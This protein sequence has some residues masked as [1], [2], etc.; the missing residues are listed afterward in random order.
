MRWLL[1][2]LGKEPHV[3]F[4][5]NRMDEVADLEDETDFE[6]HVRVKRQALLQTLQ[7]ICGRP[8]D[9]E[10]VAISADPYEQGLEDWLE[11]IEEY[12]RLSRLQSL[13]VAIE[14]HLGRAAEQIQANAGM[15]SVRDGIETV[16]NRLE[17][18]RKH[19]QPVHEMLAQREKE[20]AQECDRLEQL[21]NEAYLGIREDVEAMRRDLFDSLDA[22]VD[23]RALKN[24]IERDIGEDGMVLERKI[25]NIVERWGQSLTGQAK[26]IFD[27]VAAS[28]EENDNLFSDLM[29]RGG[30]ELI[31]VFQ[32]I[33]GGNTRQIADGAIRIRDALN[34][35]IK[36]KPWGAVKLAKFLK[37]IAWLA[38]L[39]EGLPI[40]IEIIQEHKLRSLVTELKDVVNQALEEF[41]GN[42][43]RDE[44]ERQACPGLS[45]IR[46]MA[47]EQETDLL[48]VRK[49]L[50]IIDKAVIDFRNLRNYG[51][52]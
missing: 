27:G 17:D 47:K 15:A 20:L 46:Q 42:F 8:C 51:W 30:P 52:K 18:L 5:I 22:C 1:V 29:K 38:P 4:A 31:K 7:E 16:L 14:E 23:Q 28:M 21:V 45:E 49:E 36:F 19:L 3:I 2:D 33:F 50:R 44:F 48:Q 6:N 37:K 40:I 34:I 35:P 25:T 9:P 12:E 26:P 11:N 10:V 24:L 39:L 13:I 41:F 43:T 32:K